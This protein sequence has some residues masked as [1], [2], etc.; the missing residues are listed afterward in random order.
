MPEPFLSN[1]T[2]TDGFL[3]ECVPA[4]VFARDYLKVSDRTFQRLINQPDGLPVVV[5]SPRKQFVHVPTGQAWAKSRMRQ[6]NPVRRG[7][8]A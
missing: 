1:A 7:R 6:R 8:A 4:D 2:D 5:L 3:A